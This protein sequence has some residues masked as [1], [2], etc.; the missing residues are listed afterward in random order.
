MKIPI[1]TPQSLSSIIVAITKIFDILF[2]PKLYPYITR[3]FDFLIRHRFVRHTVSPRLGIFYTF[4]SF[5]PTNFHRKLIRVG[6]FLLR[7]NY[8]KSDSWWFFFNVSTA[9]MRYVLVSLQTS[10]RGFLLVDLFL[11]VWINSLS[12]HAY[13][14][15]TPLYNSV[16]IHHPTLF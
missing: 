15:Q 11:A 4:Q 2:F 14:T 16:S 9:D 10:I 12:W 13:N 3:F 1:P 5:V 6:L 8:N 7:S